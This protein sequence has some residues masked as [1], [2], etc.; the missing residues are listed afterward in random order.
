MGSVLTPFCQEPRLDEGEPAVAGASTRYRIVVA[1]IDHASSMM[2]AR[3]TPEP[4]HD[5]RNVHFGP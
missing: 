2:S 3:N 5:V 1:V 4:L